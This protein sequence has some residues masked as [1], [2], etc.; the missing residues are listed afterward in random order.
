MSHMF[1]VLTA[2]SNRFNGCVFCRSIKRPDIWLNTIYALK[3]LG[4]FAQNNCQ[5][6]GQ[7]CKTVLHK[8]LKNQS[9]VVNALQVKRLHEFW[10][11]NLYLLQN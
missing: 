9:L 5:T 8:N 3:G 11:Q 6:K 4:I 7:T 1:S 2:L 10:A